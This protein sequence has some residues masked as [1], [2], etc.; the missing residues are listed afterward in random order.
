[1]QSRG[2]TSPKDAGQAIAT[3][4]RDGATALAA[5]AAQLEPLAVDAAAV[6]AAL[7]LLTAG[8]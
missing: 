8:T 1:L 6:R 3:L 5:L 4:Q 7:E 2:F